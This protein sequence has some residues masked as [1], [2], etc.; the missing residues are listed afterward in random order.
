MS[1]GPGVR[2]QAGL[3]ATP[4]PAGGLAGSTV[5]LVAHGVRAEDRWR[6]RLA[7][8]EPV[9]LGRDAGTWQVPWERFLSRRHAELCWRDGRLTVTALPEARNP[10]FVRGQPAGSFDLLPG[11]HFVIGET[12]FALLPEQ[13]ATLAHVPEPLHELTFGAEELQRARFHDASHKIDVLSRLPEVISR[14]ANDTELFVRLVNLLLAGIPP[15][16]VVALIAV[17]PGADAAGSVAVLHWDRRRAG[18]GDFRPSQRLVLEAVSRRRQSVLHV[19]AAGHD[20]QAGAFTEH[21]NLDWAFCTPVRG[22]ACKGWG[23]YVAGRLGT[24]PG[25]PAPLAD[26][27][28][29]QDELKFTELVASIFSSLR[30][31]QQLQQRQ[32]SL[33]HFFSPAVLRT[34]TDNDP[35]LVLKP[36]ATEVSV[37]FCDLRGFSRETA[38]HKDDLFPLLERVS[39]AL[40]VMT[41]NIFDHGGVLADFQGDAAMGFWG[42]PIDQ[43]DAVKRACLSALCIRSLFEAVANRPEHPLVG[44]HVGIGIATGPAVAGKIGSRDQAKIGVFGPVVNLASRLEG[45]TK[46][47][48]APILLDEAT[49][50]AVKV[51]LPATVARCRRLALVKPA[52][53]EEEPPLTVSELLPPFSEFPVLTDEHLA[54][55]ETA[56]HHFMKGDWD[57]ALELLHRI[58]PADCAKDFVTEIILQHKRTPPPG[59]DGVIRLLAK[60]A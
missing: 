35:E 49:A 16:E 57:Q 26:P 60:K 6:R 36:R 28:V 48:R 59:W 45:M 15:A 22:E 11:E 21:G 42:W 39:K 18:E 13:G 46:I 34:L 47:L 40:G 32:A 51:Q 56:L 3:G 19:W 27:A 44:F 7:A 5:E 20:P 14:A 30:Q 8:G 9:V 12:V 24:G 17:H 54:S 4:A 50:G 2:E 41:Q 1:T 10:I 52:G 37:L 31:V 55:Y 25:Q 23:I 33:G 29:M 38:K 43:P 53:L 58:P